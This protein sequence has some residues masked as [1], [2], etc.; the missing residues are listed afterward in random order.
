MMAWIEN[1]GVHI[2]MDWVRSFWW[3]REDTLN[4]TLYLDYGNGEVVTIKDNFQQKYWDACHA[5]GQKM[6]KRAGE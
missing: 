4:A 3:K 1:N 6:S 2:N 5:T